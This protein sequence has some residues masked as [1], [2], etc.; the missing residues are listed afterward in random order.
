MKFI[1]FE[2]IEGSG[3]STQ[4]KK[5]HA[6]FLKKSQDAI[7]TREP[8][9]TKASEQI[10][11]I[12]ITQENLEAKTELLLNFAS[13]NEHVEKLIKPSLQNNKIVICDRFFDS[14]YAYQGSAMGVDFALIDKI[15]DFYKDRGHYILHIKGKGGKHR[16]LPITKD[17]ALQIEEYMTAMAN[18]G[19]QL[20]NEDFLIQSSKKEKNKKPINGS[21]IYR[22]IEKYSKLCGINKKVGPHSCRATA[23]SHLLDTKKTPIRDVAIFAGHSNITTTERYDK[24]RESLDNSAAYDI[25][26][27]SD[28]I[29]SNLD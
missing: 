27:E 14:T 19:L 15:K 1:T 23:I 12:L 21:T 8:G 13:R 22:I 6:Y 26:Y 4:S 11:E 17:L 28:G 2:G 3:K 18:F 24:R 9:G 20:S 16:H 10:R 5:L 7:L 29:L 25:D